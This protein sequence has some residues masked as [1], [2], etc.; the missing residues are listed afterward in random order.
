MQ[1]VFKNFTV[2]NQQWRQTTWK[3]KHFNCIC[4]F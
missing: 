2:E 1:F 3:R 4:K